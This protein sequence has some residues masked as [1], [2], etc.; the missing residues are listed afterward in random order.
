MGRVKVK[1]AWIEKAA[2]RNTAYK[3]RKNGL[4]KKVKELST[5]C[6]VKACAII[7]P[8]GGMVPEVWSSTPNPMDVLVPF[9]QEPELETKKKMVN[10]VSFLQQQNMKL[11]ELALK[12]EKENKELE[13][14]VLLGQCLEGKDLSG[15]DL[16][17]ISSLSR[18]VDNKLKLVKE[19]VAKKKAEMVADGEGSS[20]P[21]AAG[22]HGWC[23]GF[24]EQ[25]VIIGEQSGQPSCGNV[26]PD[27]GNDDNIAWFDGIFLG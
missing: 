4:L 3:K 12:Q 20:T 24:N 18:L 14:I 22:M 6:D 9:M 2:A 8:Y 17:T 15:L 19:K 7:Y 16:E 11:E 13:N 1:L 26:N 21:S 10:Q 25:G 23:L 27:D 5:L